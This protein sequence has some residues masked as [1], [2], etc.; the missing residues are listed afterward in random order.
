MSEDARDIVIRTLTARITELEGQ[1]KAAES[2]RE[3]ETESRIAGDYTIAWQRERADRAEARMAEHLKGFEARMDA[4]RKL[5]RVGGVLCAEAID[6]WILPH[7]KKTPRKAARLRAKVEALL[8]A[9]QDP[10]L[11]GAS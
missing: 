8:S 7:A 9:A 5:V 11:G 10:R 2:A 3:A 4:V 1:V 6:A